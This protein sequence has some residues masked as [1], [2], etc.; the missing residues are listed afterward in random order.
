MDFFR[1]SIFCRMVVVLLTIVLQID[2]LDSIISPQSDVDSQL[3]EQSIDQA[4]N[5]SEEDDETAYSIIHLRTQQ[6]GRT[7]VL[8][9]HLKP[10]SSPTPIIICHQGRCYFSNHFILKEHRSLQT[11]FCVYRI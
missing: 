4:D 8:F 5:G 9:S 7:Q 3:L 11:L 10:V 6:K 2:I 1:R